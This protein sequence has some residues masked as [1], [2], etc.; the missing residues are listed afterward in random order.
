M[1]GIMLDETTYSSFS[2]TESGW[3]SKGKPGKLSLNTA[4]IWKI[5]KQVPPIQQ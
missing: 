2:I 5:T 1:S 4:N 3:K